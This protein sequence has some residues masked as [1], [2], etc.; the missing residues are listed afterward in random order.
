MVCQ[1][2]QYL[3]D[4]TLD[5]CPQGQDR[6]TQQMV[7]VLGFVLFFRWKFDLHLNWD[8]SSLGL[9]LL[10]KS[11]QPMLPTFPF[12]F[13]FSSS[14]FSRFP[15]HQVCQILSLSKSGTCYVLTVWCNC[16]EPKTWLPSTIW[17]TL[18][19]PLAYSYFA[20][21]KLGLARSWAAWWV[22]LCERGM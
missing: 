9:R 2:E 10:E 15:R 7:V 21:G 8:Y 19:F 5:R 6:G 1:S 17:Q 16:F 12:L 13:L 11:T 20:S 3:T 22:W 18:N 14:P 4:G